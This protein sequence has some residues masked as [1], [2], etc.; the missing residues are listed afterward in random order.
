MGFPSKSP[1]TGLKISVVGRL[2]LCYDVVGKY[3]CTLF[4]HSF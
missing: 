1:E 3:N 2:K 4:T